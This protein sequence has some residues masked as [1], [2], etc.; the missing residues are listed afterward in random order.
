MYFIKA[1]ILAAI[2]LPSMA[3]ALDPPKE[4]CSNIQW[5]PE[6]LKEYPKAPVACREITIKDGVKYAK[7]NG[8]VS[9]TDNKMVQVE[10]FN[11]ADTPISTIAFQIGVG[12]RI[13]VDG[14]EERVKDLKVGD[15]LTFWV[16]ENQFGISPTLTEQP[17]RIIKPGA[18]KD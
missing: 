4:T 9:K 18:M 7:F 3:L 17:M 1:L 5:S 2:V 13:T 14:K 16:R 11:V 12:G 6:F 15:V 8:K 10:I